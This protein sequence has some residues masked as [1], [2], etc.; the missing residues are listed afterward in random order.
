MGAIAKRAGV[1][2][3][4]TRR[5]GSPGRL[6]ARACPAFASKHQNTHCVRTP[7]RLRLCGKRPSGGY[8]GAFTWTA[9]TPSNRTGRRRAAHLARCRGAL[10]G[11]CVGRSRGGRICP[12]LSARVL[13]GP[14]RGS[15]R[16]PRLAR[17]ASSGSS[18]IC[19]DV[20]G[21]VTVRWPRLARAV[22]SV[23]A[24]AG[25]VAASS[26]GLVGLPNQRGPRRSDISL[27]IAVR[28]AWGSWR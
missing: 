11:A 22:V 19:G 26:S 3:C 27:L 10:V 6:P 4:Q 17:S 21:A 1:Q 28:S 24:W 25:W 7:Q 23:A 14:P 2:R 20:A 16:G 18:M 8:M 13:G 5:T 15:G 12:G 9:V